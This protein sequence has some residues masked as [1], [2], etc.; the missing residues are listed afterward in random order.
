MKL[1]FFHFKNLADLWKNINCSWNYIQNKGNIQYSL[2]YFSKFCLLQQ[3]LA[4]RDFCTKTRLFN[5][6][7]TTKTKTLIKAILES[8]YKFLKI[9]WKTISL[10]QPIHFFT[11]RSILSYFLRSNCYNFRITLTKWIKLFFFKIAP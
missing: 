8:L 4:N 10:R 6:F 3:L 1:T 11:G 7:K 2:G 9:P 5:I